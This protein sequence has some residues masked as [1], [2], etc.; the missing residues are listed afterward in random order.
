[1]KA[2]FIS[3]LQSLSAQQI[4]GKAAGA[5]VLRVLGAGLQFLFTVLL[6]R[7]YGAAGVGVFVIGLSL[8]VVSSTIARWG[9]DQTSMKLVAAR[10]ASD[11]P[12]Q[13]RHILAFSAKFI[14]F[15]GVAGTALLILLSKPLSLVFFEDTHASLD[16]I[17]VMALAILPLSF[18][19]LF[20]E[21][22]RGLHR[23]LAYTTLH[24]TL[25]PL[26]SILYLLILVN[27]FDDVIA[28]AIAYAL[29]TATAMIVSLALWF[30]ALT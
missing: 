15:S 13:I 27:L 30:H 5:F 9:L 24:G 17:F 20:A 22:L 18:T 14:L 25:I 11:E 21:A 26:L 28:G 29:A 19:T 4:V 16:I 3:A 7:F 1:M 6:A 2:R 23:I 10:M 8:L 12:G